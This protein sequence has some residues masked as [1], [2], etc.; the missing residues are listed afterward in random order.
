MFILNVII[1]NK[2]IT[3]LHILLIRLNVCAYV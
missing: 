2:Y 1:N 3:I